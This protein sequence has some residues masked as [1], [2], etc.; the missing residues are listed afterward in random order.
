MLI[1]NFWLRYLAVLFIFS[2]SEFSSCCCSFFLSDGGSPADT[3]PL[4]VQG[5]L[6]PAQALRPLPDVSAGPRLVSWLSLI[7]NFASA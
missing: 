3:R 4:R 1:S 2:L 7:F 6:Q 5:T